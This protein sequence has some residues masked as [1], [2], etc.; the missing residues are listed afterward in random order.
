MRALKI[1][2]WALVCEFA[3]ISSCEVIMK[4]SKNRRK[5]R[6]RGNGTSW[7]PDRKEVNEKEMNK[8]R[9][10]LERIR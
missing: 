6:R 5:Q 8:K 7:C 4:E 9:K 3:C 2:S 1:S 10:K